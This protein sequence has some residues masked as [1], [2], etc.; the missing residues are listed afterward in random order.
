MLVLILMP[1]HLSLLPC[2][3]GLT[4]TIA[5]MFL[6]APTTTRS[7]YVS[8]AENRSSGHFWAELK[9]IRIHF[10]RIPSMTA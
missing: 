1:R 6:V 9:C 4:H 3:R 2:V 10:L 7:Q 5:T 8:A